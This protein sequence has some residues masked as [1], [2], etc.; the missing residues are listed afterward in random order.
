MDLQSL[1]SIFTTFLFLL[2]LLKSTIKK[3]SSSKDVT[4]LPP[5]PRK[6]PIIGNMHNLVGSM[7][8]ECLRNLASKY[9]PLMHL[10]LGEVSHIIVTSPE[11]AQDFEDS[12]SQ[13]L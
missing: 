11:M 12:R 13:F 5:G 8:H 4:N 9:G 6:L 3:F 2:M 1:I 7:P 10:K